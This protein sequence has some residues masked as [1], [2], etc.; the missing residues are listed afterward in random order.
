MTVKT[1]WKSR[2]RRPLCL[3]KDRVIKLFIVLPKLYPI[4]ELLNYLTIVQ[5]TVNKPQVCSNP[6]VSFQEYLPQFGHLK[7]YFFH[8]KT[9]LC[10]LLSDSQPPIYCLI[11]CGCSKNPGS[12]VCEWALCLLVR[13]NELTRGHLSQVAHLKLKKTLLSLF[14]HPCFCC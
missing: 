5:A 7:I 12:A 8:F 10:T 13:K 2:Q 1:E 14:F 11:L 6:A 9:C 4:S 3:S